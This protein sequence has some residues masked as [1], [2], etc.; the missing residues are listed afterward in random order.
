MRVAATMAE[1]PD[2]AAREAAEEIIAVAAAAGRGLA[3]FQARSERGHPPGACRQPRERGA[4]S[5]ARELLAARAAS[6]S[7]LLHGRA[8]LRAERANCRMCILDG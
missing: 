3:R 1:F 5:A 6:A 4:E 7:D 8:R 2:P